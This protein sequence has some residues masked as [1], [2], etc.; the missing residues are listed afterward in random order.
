MPVGWSH[1]FKLWDQA[2]PTSSADP[3]NKS[4][5]IPTRKYM[6][7]KELRDEYL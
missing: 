7:F 3:F 2:V 5:S 1:V 6:S 4:G